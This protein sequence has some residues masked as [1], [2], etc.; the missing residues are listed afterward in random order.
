MLREVVDPAT[1]QRGHGEDHADRVERLG[2]EP[3]PA[4]LPGCDETSDDDPDRD[5]QAVPRDRDGPQLDGGI[6][7]DGDGR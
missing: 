2:V 5:R 4:G 1:D 6:D 3:A 7:A